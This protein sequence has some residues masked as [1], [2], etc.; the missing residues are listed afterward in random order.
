MPPKAALT[1]FN[2]SSVSRSASRSCSSSS[3]SSA[4]AAAADEV[5]AAE[6]G[7]GRSGPGV[8]AAEPPLELGVD[9]GIGRRGRTSPPCCCCCCQA[10]VS[11][12][13]LL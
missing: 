3:S 9:S 13:R 8:A 2:A 4:A 11:L 5:E 1:I 7:E 10:S 6:G 12:A